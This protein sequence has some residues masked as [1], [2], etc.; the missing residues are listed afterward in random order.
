MNTGDH[1]IAHVMYRQPGAST[2]VLVFVMGSWKS[3]CAFFWGVKLLNHGQLIAIVPVFPSKRLCFCMQFHILRLYPCTTM[4]HGEIYPS[5]DIH[6]GLA[7]LGLSES[8]P[9]LIA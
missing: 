9:Y 3:F 7:L 5:A 2:W 1:T 8:H 6:L 4:A